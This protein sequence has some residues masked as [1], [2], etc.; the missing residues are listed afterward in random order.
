[1]YAFVE[2]VLERGPSAGAVYINCGESSCHCGDARA[3]TEDEIATAIARCAGCFADSVA[4]RDGI[5][6]GED[7]DPLGWH[8]AKPSLAVEDELRWFGPSRRFPAS[9]L[10]ELMRN[11]LLQEI[12][13]AGRASRRRRSVHV[14]HSSFAGLQHWSRSRLT[15]SGR[16]AGVAVLLKVIGVTR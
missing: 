12:P 4:I 1:M 15:T 5:D 10:R 11:A 3:Y 13:V 14:S 7:R 16:N 2:A 9:T 6:S 8:A